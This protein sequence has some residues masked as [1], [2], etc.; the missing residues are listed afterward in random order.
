MRYYLYRYIIVINFLLFHNENRTFVLSI[1][2]DKI[3]Y[4]YVKMD[5]NKKYFINL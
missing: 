3:K 5:T 1:T 4:I 2:F